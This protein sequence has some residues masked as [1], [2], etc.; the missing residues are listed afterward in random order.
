MLTRAIPGLSATVEVT[1]GSVANNQL[2]GADRVGMVITQV[3]AAVDAVRGV[4][5]FRGRPVNVRAPSPCSTPTACR[6]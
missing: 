2:L 1:G 6:W 5:R 3:D 4:E